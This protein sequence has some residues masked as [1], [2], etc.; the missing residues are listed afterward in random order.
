[1]KILHINDSY[2]YSWAEKIYRN[3]YLNL[4]WKKIEL[5]DYLFKNNFLKL[6]NKFF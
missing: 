4:W 2:I 3:V 5:N 6:F 1:M